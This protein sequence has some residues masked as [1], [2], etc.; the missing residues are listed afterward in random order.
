M[1]VNPPL[2]ETLLGAP[3]ATQMQPHFNINSVRLST[4]TNSVGYQFDEFRMGDTF[5]DVVPEPAAS[6]AALVAAGLLALR[7]R[8]A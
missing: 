2:D 5:A 7:R 3:D 1:W 6:G 4:G 8:R